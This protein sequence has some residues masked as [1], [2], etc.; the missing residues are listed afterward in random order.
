LPEVDP[1]PAR[2]AWAM[3]PQAPSRN[4]NRQSLWFASA[5]SGCGRL[6]SLSAGSQAML[7]PETVVFSH[8]KQ[9]TLESG[10]LIILESGGNYS[11]AL[12]AAASYDNGRLRR[13]R[14]RPLT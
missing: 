14:P 10:R 7:P 9:M 6:Q 13:Q 11:R 2:A 3:L 1:G 8:C 12:R 5:V 4:E